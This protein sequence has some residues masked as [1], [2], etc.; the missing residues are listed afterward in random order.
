MHGPPRL[1]RPMRTHKNIHEECEQ[2]R[3]TRRGFTLLELLVVIFV[4]MILAAIAVGRYQQ[5]LKHAH[6]A[7]LKEDL[8]VM[9]D[10]IQRYAQDKG[11]W[12]SS[13]DDLKTAGYIGD[14]PMDPIT[15][16]KDWNT[17]SGDCDVLSADQISTTGICGVSSSSTGIALDGSQYS[18]W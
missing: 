7:V 1:A 15:R 3:P 4:I 9:R 5:T 13:L 2:Q 16:A 8:S 12:P 6:E 17:E 10:A 14:V 18:S 11:G